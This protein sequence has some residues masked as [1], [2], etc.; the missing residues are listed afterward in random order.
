[1]ISHNLRDA[2]KYA[3]RIVMLDKGKIILD[4]PSKNV[5]EEELSKIYIYKLNN[6]PISIAI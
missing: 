4:I 5:T 2:I 6:S 3:D 1:M